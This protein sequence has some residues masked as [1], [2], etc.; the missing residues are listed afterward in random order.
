MASAATS[1]EHVVAACER[2]IDI[3]G[4]RGRLPTPVADLVAAAELHEGEEDI[5]TEA[6][7]ARAPRELQEKIRRLGLLRKVRAAIDRR[8][9]VVYVN[10]EIQIIGRRNFNTLHEVAHDIFDWQRDLAYA[11][12]DRTLAWRTHIRF[13]RE[14]NQG[15]A[16][17][18]FQLQLF[19]QIA[20]DYRIG[21][22]T[23]VDLAQMFGASTQ[24]VLRRYVETHSHPMAAV[25]CQRTPVS[26][27]PLEAQ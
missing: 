9:R 27:V 1:T 5:F 18:L 14:A 16:E 11:D 6:A 21:M 4:A 15:A 2:L 7:L 13:E 22:A 26:L 10:P 25:V 24:A 23:I 20:A 19:R 3:A 12:D 17:L 8:E